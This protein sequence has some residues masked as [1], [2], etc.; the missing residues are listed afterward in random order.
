MERMMTKEAKV[1]APDENA[2]SPADE[3]TAR[4]TLWFVR[5]RFEAAV[6]ASNKA[7]GRLRA[8]IMS[9]RTTGILTVDEM[10]QAVGRDRNYIDTM[11]STFGGTKRY[12]DGRVHQTRVAPAEASEARRAE[13]RK[14]LKR[15]GSAQQKT[16]ASVNDMRAERNRVIAITYGS[17][18]LGPSAIASAV[19]VDRNHVLRIARKHGVKPMHRAVTRNQ[20]SAAPDQNSAAAVPAD[21][22]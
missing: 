14:T 10:A 9:M 19:G 5:S 21:A 6:S 16:A 1:R 17:K 4:A 3:A 7:T 8:T 18:V 12:A 13:A 2:P 11:W 20:Y 15:L 22:A